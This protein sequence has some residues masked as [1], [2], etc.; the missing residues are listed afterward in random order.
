M[1][2]AYRH[3]TD[4]VNKISNFPRHHG[5]IFA[6]VTTTGSSSKTVA[7]FS[8]VAGI[9]VAV[10]PRRISSSSLTCSISAANNCRTIFKMAAKKLEETGQKSF[11]SSLKALQ[12]TLI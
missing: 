3:N 5:V 6:T 2:S 1:A 7:S 11:V 4:D 9:I 12:S 10:V 8:A